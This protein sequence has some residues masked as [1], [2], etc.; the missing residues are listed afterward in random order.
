MNP[1][2]KEEGN[3]LN[4]IA[5]SVLLKLALAFIFVALCGLLFNYFHQQSLQK[6]YSGQ[7]N[8]AIAPTE[9]S[10]ALLRVK[11]GNNHP[12]VAKT[13][14]DLAH[15][16]DL[17]GNFAKADD[18]FRQSNEIYQHAPAQTD[19]LYGA[20]MCY[21]ADHLVK[22][23]NYDEAERRY[24]EALSVTENSLGR[25]SKE[26]AWILQRMRNLYVQLNRQDE[27]KELNQRAERILSHRT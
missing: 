7:Y 6:F 4:S 20:A 26:T 25:E 8:S 19:S 1:I 24:K 27:A 11:L 3:G 10:I 23:K 17:N 22:A 9:A 13:L 12:L 15:L 16:Y 21:Y 14:N 5:T 2:G 18:L